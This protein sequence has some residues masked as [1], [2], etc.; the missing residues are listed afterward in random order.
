MIIGSF[1]P[2]AS[3]LWHPAL[4]ELA[5]RHPGHELIL[6]PAESERRVAELDAI[7]GGRLDHG[8]FARA[9]RLK[10]VFVPFTGLNHLP[11]ELLK[12]RKVRAFNVHGNAESVAER[13]LAMTLAFYGRLVEFHNDLRVE[14][15]HG[16]WVGKGAEDEWSSIFR[17]KAAIFGTGAIGIA[18]ARLLKAFDCEVVGYRRRS[19]AALPANFDRIET[20]FRRAVEGAELLFVALPLTPK[21]RGLFSKEVLLAAKGKFLVNVGRGDIV[22]EEGLWL[23]LSRGIL[24]GAAVDTWYSYPQGGS[25]RGSPSRF[26]VHTLPNVILSPHV[27]GSTAEANVIAARQTLEN[28]AEWL[29]TGN[30]AREGNLEEMY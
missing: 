2:K 18:L 27:G 14:Q 22:D 29:S 1:M 23:S 28:M 13:A 7:L 16:F 24:K 12:T 5:S 19:E 9:E 6:D 25:T 26:P 10:A 8:L 21:T 30:C 20:D 15:W 4:G 17:R 11:I 3:A